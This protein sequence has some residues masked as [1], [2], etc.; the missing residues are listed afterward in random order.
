[1]QF[2]NSIQISASAAATY[3]L[4]AAVESWPAWDPEVE[5]SS[6]SG[7]FAAGNMGMLK[8]RGGPE[9]RFELIEASPG[10]SFSMR[11]KLP[12]CQMTFSHELAQKGSLTTATHSVLF[13]GPLSAVFGFLIGRGIKKTLPTTMSGLKQAAEK[14]QRASSEA[15]TTSSS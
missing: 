5:R 12:L 15:L 10:K 11:C 8:P 7:P 2:S 14:R 13:S 9:S 4:Y 3:E 6:I 1:M